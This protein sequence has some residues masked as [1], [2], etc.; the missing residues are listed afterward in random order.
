MRKTLSLL[1]TLLVVA[2]AA[3]AEPTIPQDAARIEAR[4]T[5][6][7]NG[8][9]GRS[10][11]LR[12]GRQEGPPLGRPGRRGARPR[13][14]DVRP[15]ADP[16]VFPADIHA[17]AKKAVDAGCDDPLVLYIYARMSLAS[18]TRPREY[19]RRFLAAADALAASAY[20]GFR[21]AARP[22]VGERPAWKKDPTP[23]ERRDA[24]RGLDAV[25]DLLPESAAD[26]AEAPDWDD[27]WFTSSSP[28]S[29]RYRPPLRR[30]QGR[31]RPGRRP[32]RQ[33]QRG[34]SPPARASRGT[35]TPL[36]LGGPHRPASPPPS[37]HRAVPRPSRS[38]SRR[39]AT[40]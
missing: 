16:L 6:R 38:G 24:E 26:D 1:P 7:W 29:R 4:G 20:P 28:P 8:I 37:P 23:D 40:P 31:L 30:S 39:P 19:A 17:P 2:A 36:G 13:R 5:P 3:A 25:L 33:G 12:E 32:A 14:P 15:Q 10:G 11:G 22:E 35:S 18:T 21:K 27:R 34:R 9:G